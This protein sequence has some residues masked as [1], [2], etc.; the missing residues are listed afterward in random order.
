VEPN[1]GVDIWKLTA[2]LLAPPVSADAVARHLGSGLSSGALRWSASAVLDI[3]L[4]AENG[5]WD[6]GAR[7]CRLLAAAP[8]SG[9]GALLNDLGRTM[10][11]AH[12]LDPDHA[13]RS[14]WFER[15]SAR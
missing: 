3:R 4:P 9:R 13:V 2:A 12:G 11:I 10:C 5:A 8:A 14:W 15:A 1:A 6:E 7:L